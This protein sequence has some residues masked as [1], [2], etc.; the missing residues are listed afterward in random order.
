MPSRDPFTENIRYF[1][2]LCLPF[3][4][5]PAVVT[6]PPIEHRVEQTV[7]VNWNQ[8]EVQLLDLTSAMYYILKDEIPRRQVIEGENMKALKLWIHMLKKYAPGTVPIRR[9]FYRLNEWLSPAQQVSAEQ[10]IAEVDSVQSDLG[11][12][13][14]TNMTWLACRG[15]KPYVRGYSCGIWTLLHAVTVQAYKIEENSE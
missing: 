15:S 12:P 5:Q 2:N 4:E 14:P 8:F 7:T 3:Q 10:W 11:Y 6:A 1:A 13:L 9:L